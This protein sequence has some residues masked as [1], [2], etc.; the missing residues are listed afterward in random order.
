MK[1]LLE[2]IVPNIVNHPEDVEINE[3]SENGVVTLTIKVNPEDTGR[4]I[5][6]AGKVIKAIRQIARVIAIKQGVRVNIDVLDGQSQE[7]SA[8]EE[9][10]AEYASTEENTEE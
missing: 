6:K 5:G 1:Q 4:V 8:T 7:G 2:Y 9:V 3:T 10:A